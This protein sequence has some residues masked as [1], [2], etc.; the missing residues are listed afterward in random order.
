MSSSSKGRSQK[1]AAFDPGSFLLWSHPVL[2]QLSLGYSRLKDRLLMYYAPVRRCTQG[3]KP[4]FS[5]DLHVLS[6]PPAFAL[7]QDQTLQLNMEREE[8]SSQQ[9]LGHL[10]IC[11]LAFSNKW[12]KKPYCLAFKE[13]T[14][15]RISPYQRSTAVSPRPLSGVRWRQRTLL[16]GLR[17]TLS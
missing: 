12:R 15:F 8:I 16:S 9:N 13:L 10:F 7:S 4:P 5:L 14:S 11:A 6:T 3:P 2:A 1:E 17:R